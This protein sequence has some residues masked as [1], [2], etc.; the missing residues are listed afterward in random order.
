MDRLTE[1]DAP[2]MAMGVRIESLLVQLAERDALITTLE[3]RVESIAVLE[4]KIDSLQPQVAT[5]EARLGEEVSEL[6]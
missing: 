6:L 1:R 2:I 3:A 5:L 4:A